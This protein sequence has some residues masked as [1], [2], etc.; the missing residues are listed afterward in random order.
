M[1]SPTVFWMLSI[2]GS[3]LLCWYGWLRDD[4]SII[5][6]QFI[7]YYIYLWNLYEK[8]VWTKLSWLLRAVL[9]LTPLL[10]GGLMLHDAETFMND[11]LRNDKIPFWLLLFGSAGQIIFTLRF[12]Y[13]WIYSYRLKES[14][15]PVGFWIISLVG[16]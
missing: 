14:L 16:S 2:A 7:A 11:F 3:Y 13:Q 8:K 10:V 9:M 15:L 5:L 1:E 4:F 6:G 12:V